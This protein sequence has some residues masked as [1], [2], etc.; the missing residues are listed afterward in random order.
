VTPTVEGIRW[1]ISSVVSVTDGDTLR[2]I[3]SR[4]LDVDGRKFWV[5]DAEEKGVPVRLTWLDTPERGETG[6]GA[7][8][9]DLLAWI[10]SHRKL[11]LEVII[12]GSAGW[13]RVLGDVRCGDESASQWMMQERGWLP[14]T[15]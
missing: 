4:L 5:T 9:T 8:R 13:D 1:N 7:A 11:G 6:W 10:D 3:R 15:G 12:Y 14:F 2:A